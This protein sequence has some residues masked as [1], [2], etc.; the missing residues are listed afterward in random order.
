M[1]LKNHYRNRKR[2]RKES[3]SQAKIKKRK[4]RATSRS[5]MGLD[6]PSYSKTK[7][8]SGKSSRAKQLYQKTNI[9]SRKRVSQKVRKPVSVTVSDVISM[10]ETRKQPD[11]AVG[12]ARLVFAAQLTRRC[13]RIKTCIGVE[14]CLF[15]HL[16]IVSMG[17]R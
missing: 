12:N 17:I 15:E 10:N 16:A 5:V 2:K 14:N 6:A 7:R 13:L 3:S 1:R 4:K 9:L 11:S 8:C